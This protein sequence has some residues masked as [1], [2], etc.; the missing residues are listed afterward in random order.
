MKLV[1]QCALFYF[2]K[3]SVENRLRLL[4]KE[5]KLNAEINFF[6]LN[7]D[8]S[9]KRTRLL[10]FEAYYSLCRASVAEYE[11]EKTIFLYIN[12]SF[13]I[14]WPYKSIIREF[15]KIVSSMGAIESPVSS[16]FLYPYEEINPIGSGQIDSHLTTCFFALNYSANKILLD[17]IENNLTIPDTVFRQWPDIFPDYPAL[18]YILN[19]H[20]NPLIDTERKN[21]WKNAIDSSESLL[22]AKARTVAIEYLLSLR[23]AKQESLFHYQ[24]R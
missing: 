12:D 23:L 14:K 22:I 8:F 15:L 6:D 7:D 18:T 24:K 4:T 5:K 11:S 17:V 3:R 1:I 9:R 21:R 13:F 19:I 20:L 2:S 16:S 10:D